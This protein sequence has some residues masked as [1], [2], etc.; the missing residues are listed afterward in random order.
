MGSEMMAVDIVMPPFAPRE[1]D[2]DLCPCMRNATPTVLFWFKDVGQAV[3]EGDPLVEVER[4]LIVIDIP[5]PVS[6]TLSEIRVAP[7]A[8]AASGEVIGVIT[9]GV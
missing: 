9:P 3:T 2:E 1:D 4:A 8:K 6:G 7:G 5:A